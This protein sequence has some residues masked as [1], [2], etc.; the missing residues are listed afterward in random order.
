MELTDTMKFALSQ[1][2]CETRHNPEATDALTEYCQV[3][4]TFLTEDAD[5]DYYWLTD[6]TLP[7]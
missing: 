6:E 3:L 2:S 5:D 1:L 7:H 4:A